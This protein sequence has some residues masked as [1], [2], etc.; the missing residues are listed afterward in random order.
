M[1]EYYSHDLDCERGLSAFNSAIAMG[2]IEP[3]EAADLLRGH[4]REGEFLARYPELRDCEEPP[5]DDTSRTD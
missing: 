2:N 1:G 5:D 4:P 3:K